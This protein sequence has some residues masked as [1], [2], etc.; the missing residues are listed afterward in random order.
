MHDNTLLDTAFMQL[1]LRSQFTHLRIVLWALFQ[2]NL[3]VSMVVLKP[4][5]LCVVRT[6]QSGGNSSIKVYARYLASVVVGIGKLVLPLH[7]YHRC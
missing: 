2:V 3:R 4:S 1:L 7:K 6:S 5:L